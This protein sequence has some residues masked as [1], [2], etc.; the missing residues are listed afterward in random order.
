MGR[1]MK[2]KSYPIYSE[3]MH[4]CMQWCLKNR[5]I[6]HVQPEV[7]LL[8]KAAKTGKYHV[9]VNNKGKVI[10]SEP[11]YTN[12]EACTKAWEICCH[13]YENRLTDTL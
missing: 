9:V 13:F 10:T 5:I 7:V 8:P 4:T 11:K 6:V 12:P 2:V 3:D 1:R